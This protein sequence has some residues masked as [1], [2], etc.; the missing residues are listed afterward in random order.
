MRNNTGL[1][2]FLGEF[3]WLAEC[4]S[5]LKFGSGK[6]GREIID[7]ALRSAPVGLRYDE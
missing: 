2:K 5:H 3:P 4:Y 1:S 7:V 6:F